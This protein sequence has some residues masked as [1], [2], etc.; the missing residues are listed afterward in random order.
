MYI[1]IQYIYI[2]SSIY[3]GYKYKRLTD[4]P[5]SVFSL[6]SRN[7][8]GKKAP[9]LLSKANYKKAPSSKLNLRLLVAGLADYNIVAPGSCR[10]TIATAVET[11]SVVVL[12]TT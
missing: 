7:G 11:G 10:R 9:P 8:N 3:I 5:V 12:I 1:Y 2:F 6:C 4:I